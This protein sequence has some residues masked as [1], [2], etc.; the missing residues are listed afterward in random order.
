M[1]LTNYNYNSWLKRILYFLTFLEFGIIL[2]PF[3]G[4][5]HFLP[6]NKKCKC[7]TLQLLR[8][9]KTIGVENN[10][11]MSDTSSNSRLSDKGKE[12]IK[13]AA[14]SIEN[15]I[16]D[17]II[18]SN[19]NRTIETFKI[20]NNNLSCVRKVV[21]SNKIKGIN[22]SV[23]AEKKF[24]M[25]DESNLLVFLEREC[26]HNVLVKTQNGDSWA[27]VIYRCAKA[28]KTINRLYS[29]KKVL[30]VSQG[31]IFQSFKILLH[32]EHTPWDNYSSYKM[33]NIKKDCSGEAI[34]YSCLSDLV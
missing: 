13:K 26:K 5:L 9:G 27:D 33:F 28:L 29:R 31:S 18:V 7:A 24:E 2:N 1:S 3:T 19:L 21:Y 8:H 16:P 32:T 25:L 12:E 30:L 15:N 23:W 17:V 14:N 6:Y 11:F 4:I 10:E 22:N 20:L 34:G